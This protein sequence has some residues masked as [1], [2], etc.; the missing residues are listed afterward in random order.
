MSNDGDTRRGGRVRRLLK[1]TLAVSCGVL[2]ALLVSEAAVRLLHT[3]SAQVRRACKLQ[4]SPSAGYEAIKTIRGLRNSVVL[5]PEPNKPWNGFILNSRG[6][7]TPE[8]KVAKRPGT[9]RVVTLG[10][11]FT[12]DSGEVPYPL[13]YTV[14]VQ[15]GLGKAMHKPVEL[16]NLAVPASGPLLQKRMLEIE[17]LRLKPD[18][19]IWTIFVGNDFVC[20]FEDALPMRLGVQSWVIDIQWLVEWSYLGR[21]L[22]YLYFLQSVQYRDRTVAREPPPGAKSGTYLDDIKDYDPDRPKMALERQMFHW[23]KRQ[24]MVA[25]SRKRFP[26]ESWR[27]ISEAL[28]EAGRRCRQAGIPLLM[29]VIPD[30]VQINRKLRLEVLHTLGEHEPAYDMTRPQRLLEQLFSQQ[31]I[32]HLD[33]LPAMKARGRTARLYA[34]R[35]VHWNSR[36]NRVAADEILGYLEKAGPA[37]K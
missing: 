25:F 15:N 9:Y 32:N 16:I 17:G 7:R 23:L 27:T 5:T 1:R 4:L 21:V 26:R 8:Y 2:V 36:G 35:D 37:L 22:R 28:V 12:F 6:L 20:E 29:V 10:D 33:L 19:I 34:P 14:L 30:E 18:L 11:S 24:N 3:V 31:R 13:H